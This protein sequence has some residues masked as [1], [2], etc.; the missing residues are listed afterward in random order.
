MRTA[1]IDQTGWMARLILVFAGHTVILL[2][3]SCRSSIIVIWEVA[4][5]LCYRKFCFMAACQNKIS[6]LMKRQNDKH[7]PGGAIKHFVKITFMLR[8]LLMKTF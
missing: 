3:L 4:G 5:Q 6:S 1:K 7:S 8:R 2:V